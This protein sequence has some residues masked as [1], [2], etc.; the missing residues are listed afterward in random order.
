MVGELLRHW[1]VL[2]LIS[3][4]HKSLQRQNGLEHTAATL[5]HMAASERPQYAF[6]IEEKF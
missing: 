6:E 4:G 1:K 5:Q 2:P 3:C